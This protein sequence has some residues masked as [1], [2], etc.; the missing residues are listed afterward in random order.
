MSNSTSTGG[1]QL[2]IGVS[3]ST[4][5]AVDP[6]DPFRVCLIQQAKKH[7]ERKTLVG[8][9]RT[10][11]DSHEETAVG[12]FFQEAG[13]KGAQLE[14]VR[15]WAI[16]TDRLADVRTVTLGRATDD[17]CPSE[18]RDLEVVAHYGYPDYF[19]V[20]SVVGTPYPKDGE[21]KAVV[22]MDVRDIVITE[23]EEDSQFGA[24]HDLVLAL[25]RYT[26]EGRS[27][28]DLAI[29]LADCKALRKLLLSLQS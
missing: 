22:W 25:Y 5:I 26:L 15:L 1:I 20:A 10:G 14:D 18:L 29:L 12:E 24:Q 23:R 9:K 2:S 16:K 28:G 7:R 19:Y 8:G 4:V 13:G 6:G 17:L 27:L 11:G 3:T 21:A